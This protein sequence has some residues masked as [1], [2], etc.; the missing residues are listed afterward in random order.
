MKKSPKILL[1]D[2]ETGT[3][4]AHV[5]EHYDTT[6]L[7][8]EKR[9]KLLSV[10]FKWLGDKKVSVISRRTKKEKD[11]VKK[12]HALFDEADFLCAHNGDEFDW[13][14][15]NVKFLS[16]GLNPPSPA[17]K[18]DTKKLAKKYFKFNCNKL[19]DLCDALG[20]GRKA[21]TGGFDLWLKCMKGDKRALKVMERY[22]KQDVVLLEK[23]YLKL[24]PWIYKQPGISI[25]QQKFQCHSCGGNHFH[26]HGVRVNKGARMRRYQC[27]GCGSWLSRKI[28][29]TS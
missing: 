27:Q 9:W 14:K 11:I 26:S 22:N 10:A 25:A 19:D 3:N 16:F 6:V 1:F 8:Y 24:R 17:I 20:I 13:K 4:Q 21:S 18:I 23:L 2:I 28:V 29:K 15:M 7:A 5:F 12:V